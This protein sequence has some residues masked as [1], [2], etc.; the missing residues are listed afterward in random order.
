MA[1]LIVALIIAAFALSGRNQSVA[2]EPTVTEKVIGKAP[3]PKKDPIPIEILPQE[4]TIIEI[5][6]LVAEEFIGELEDVVDRPNPV[7]KIIV[8]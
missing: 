1:I 8:P 3:T 6:E 4:P 2:D 5:E 7:L